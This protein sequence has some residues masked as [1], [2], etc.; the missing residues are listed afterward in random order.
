[1]HVKGFWS[2]D[3]YLLARRWRAEGCTIPEIAHRLN[4]SVQSVYFRLKGTHGFNSERKQATCTPQ[5]LA[6]AKARSEARWAREAEA[7]RTGNLT[8]LLFGDPPPGQSA[9]DE[10]G[11]GA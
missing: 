3:E 2:K 4:R 9:L 5:Q 11:R 6:D 8:P 1:M 7:L 10:K